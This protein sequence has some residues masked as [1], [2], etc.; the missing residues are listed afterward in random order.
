M[1]E[2]GDVFESDPPEGLKMGPAAQYLV[3]A[4]ML[5][6]EIAT[7]SPERRLFTLG[8]LLQLVVGKYAEAVGNDH[9]VAAQLRRMAKDLQAPDFRR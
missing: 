8:V 2:G 9:Q 4:Q 1:S 5:L 3:R 6:R 7:E